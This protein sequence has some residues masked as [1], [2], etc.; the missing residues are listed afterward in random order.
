M[1]AQKRSP[2]LTQIRDFAFKINQVPYHCK[3][4][5]HELFIG[6]TKTIAQ[7]A[8]DIFVCLYLRG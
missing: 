6:D 3:G 2:I 1:L 4:D 5:V 8:D 7:F